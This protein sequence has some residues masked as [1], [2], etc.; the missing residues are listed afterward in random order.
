MLSRLF[1]SCAAA[2]LFAAP[3]GAL[4]GF[5]VSGETR[6]RYEHVSEQFRAGLDGSDQAVSG[7]TLIQLGY[8]AGPTEWGVEIIDS[9][10]YLDDEGSPR[11]TS[12]VNTADFLQAYWRR[13]F[14][15]DGAPASVQAGRFTLNVGSRRFMARNGFRNTINAFTGANLIA[16]DLSG[17]AVTAF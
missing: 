5:S 6:W 2:A 14:T 13:R 16:E 10:V 4:D 9:R 8:E 17:W 12:R 3:S 15:L 11:S 1:A 7:R